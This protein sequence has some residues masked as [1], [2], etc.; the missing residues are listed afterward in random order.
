MSELPL[1]ED[2]AKSDSQHPM[3]KMIRDGKY[4]QERRVLL[5]WSNNFEDRDGKFCHEFQTSFEPCLWELYLHAFLKEIGAFVDFTYSSPDFI[6]N[7]EEDICIEATVACPPIG[8]PP[9]YDYSIDDLP[10]SFNKLN[11]E[12]AVRLCNSFT[13]KV[14]KLRKQY[15]TLPQCKNKP[16]ILAIASF[17]RPFSHMSS[18]SLLQ[19]EM[20]LKGRKVFPL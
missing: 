11:S 17:D 1:F 15:S 5:K 14:K 8:G 13:S 19:Y 3:Y 6:V 4:E 7:A 10:D 18:M 16:F 9:P 12:A 20:S 2:I